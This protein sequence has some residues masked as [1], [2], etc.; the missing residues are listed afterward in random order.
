M[1][2]LGCLFLLDHYK[3]Q[4][5]AYAKGP[6]SLDWDDQPSPFRRFSGCDQVS[7][8]PPGRSL[9][10]SFA[11]LDQP[12]N[13]PIQAQTFENLALMLELAFGLSAWKQYGPD[14]WALRCNP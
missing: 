3:H 6:A 14:R 4:L 2:L 12:Q 10:V 8:A 11:E 7:L 5:N 1:N 13:I 9:D